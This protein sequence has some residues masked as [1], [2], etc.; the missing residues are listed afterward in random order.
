MSQSILYIPGMFDECQLVAFSHDA[1]AL[2]HTCAAIVKVRQLVEAYPFVTQED[3]MCHVSARGAA[4]GTLQAHDILFADYIYPRA[5]SDFEQ[6]RSFVRLPND[7]VGKSIDVGVARRG[8]FFKWAAVPSLCHDADHEGMIMRGVATTAAEAHEASI[9]AAATFIKA[10]PNAIR[11]NAYTDGDPYF[12]Y[13][14]IA[15]VGE[16]A[17][18]SAERHARALH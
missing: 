7:I 9:V 10:E 14:H 12:A 4:D 6:Y 18:L 15:Q 16:A 17:V 5:R 1:A 8:T 13:T 11:V 3:V 2:L